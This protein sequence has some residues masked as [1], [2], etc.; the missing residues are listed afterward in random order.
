MAK[1]AK[2]KKKTK[3]EWDEGLPA[4][5]VNAAGIDVG[6]ADHYVAVPIGRDPE[7]SEASRRICIA[8]RN[9]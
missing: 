5:N 8:W 2:T 7:L 6:N 9:G 3:G 4:L 1:A